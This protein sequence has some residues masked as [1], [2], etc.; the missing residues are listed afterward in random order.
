MSRRSYLVAPVSLVALAAAGLYSRPADD[1][2]IPPP[3]KQAPP[4]A[5]ECRWADTPITIDGT[6]DEPA[7]K[8]AQVIDTFHLPWLGD[9][10][11]MARTATK[12]RLLWDREYLYF[13]AEM[14][15][16]DLF[17]DVLEHDGNTWTNDVF[18]L[19]FRPDREK[20]GYYEF[21]VNAAGTKFDCFFPKRDFGDFEKQKKAGDF[22]IDAKVKLR[23]T[24]NK[25]DDKDSGWSVEGRIPWTDFIRTG[26]RPEPGEAWTFNLCRYD[27]HKDWKDPELSCVAPVKGQK[28]SADFHQIEDY[29]TLTFV[30]VD[31]TTAV[32]P[33]GIE[34]REPLT[35]STVVGFPD[36]PPPYRVTRAMPNYRPAFPIMA[37]LIPGSTQM[38]LITQP[39]SY[40][41]TTVFRF[42]YADKTTEK[43]AVKV[44]E[45]PGGGTAYDIAFHPKFAENGFF[46][47][48]WN[49]PMP[50]KKGKYTQ[51]TR[52]TMKPTP[53]FD[54]DG[55]SEK[56][57]IAWE[58]DGHNGGAVC[59]GHDGMMYVTSGDGTS[60]SDTNV[61]GQRTDVLLAKVLRIDVDHPANGKEYDIPKDNPYVNDKRFV[62]ETW[63]YGLRN[64]WR[65]TCDPKTGHIWVGQNGQDLWEQA[66][67]VKK[68]DNYGW[69]VT[70]GSHPFYT[71]R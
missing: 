7:W 53:P 29:A 6:D 65:I 18:E 61:M 63:A 27:Y 22:H 56:L 52:Y 54:V 19:F 33:F 62:P 40:G 15:D 48:G 57:I 35:T 13:F 66:F 49:G 50:D 71:N 4:T 68:G 69:S 45:T 44:L 26:G 2:P 24:L 58:S 3:L 64:P 1:H 14:E 70:E 37:K 55:K 23:G 8:H 17:A 41:P 16:T 10:A 42:D 20:P 67:L 25:R 28:G 60:D 9:K 5:F 59:F 39:W 47:I 43:D 34:K 38:L 21:Q 11:R 31:A 51:V 36:P 30:G 46:Y 32:R 12:A